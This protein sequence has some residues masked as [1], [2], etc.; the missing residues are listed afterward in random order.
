MTQ[1]RRRS[2][3]A[4]L[5]A[6][7]ALLMGGTAWARTD[8]CYQGGL[9]LPNFKLNGSALLNGT[10]LLVTPDQG[11]QIASAMYIPT[12]AATS[13]VHIQLKLQITTTVT[14][15]ADGMTFVMHQDPRGAAALGD[16]GGGIGYGGTA[17]ITP[18]IIVEMDTYKNAY[19]LN[20]NHIGVMVDG[21]EQDHKA[22]FTPLF[23]MKTVGA[24]FYVWIDYTASLTKLD[25]YI[26]QTA[27]KPVLPQLTY[28]VNVAQKFNNQPFYMG[29]TGSTGGA[30]SQHEILSFIASDSVITSS[31]CCT[32]NTD[33][34]GSPLGPQC[35]PVK[36]VCGR[37]SPADVSSCPAGSGCDVGGSSNTCVPTCTSNYG[38]GQT[39]ACPSANAPFCVL[40]GP[41]KGSCTACNGNYGS[42]ATYACPQGAPSCNLSGFCG[43]CTM[44]SECQVACNTDVRTCAGCGGDFGST[45]ANACPTMTT[46]FCTA[47]KLCSVCTKDADCATGAHAGPLCNKT[48]GACAPKCSGDADCTGSDKGPFCNTDSGLCSNSCTQDAQCGAGKYCDFTASSAGGS[49]ADK[50]PNGQPL[51]TATTFCTPDLASRMCQ[52]GICSSSGM[53]VECT[54]QTGCSNG[55]TC[56][57]DNT[58][59]NIALSGGGFS[60]TTSSSGSSNGAGLAFMAFALL[61]IARR[62]KLSQLFSGRA[63]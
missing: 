41:S 19:D 5:V 42:G 11:N 53:C 6:L 39:G 29:F 14:E 34:T 59:K 3:L 54:T 44:N 50:I 52:S 62:Q 60:C 36:H 4:P 38:S 2:W 58:C 9:N 43:L 49:C 56:T 32:S 1:L 28:L 25:V 7:A 51:P 48:T 23:N 18:S 55:A 35:D 46:P 63:A 45:A 26:S 16:A 15:G 30:Q 61:L 22:V 13:D 37:C 17:K 8:V 57:S 47:G 33:C 24:P 40:A 21:N 27:T 20:A 12:F 31:V 10:D